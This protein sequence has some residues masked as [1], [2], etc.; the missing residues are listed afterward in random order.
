MSAWI[1]LGGNNFDPY[2][3]QAGTAAFQYW[4]PIHGYQPPVYRTFVENPGDS[5]DPR[6]HYFFNVSCNTHIYV[7]VD[8]PNCM[9]LLDIDT[10]VSTTNKCYGHDTSGLSG[11]ALVERSRNTADYPYFAR[12]NSVTFHGVAI[13]D[14][15]HYD[16][17]Y[18]VPHNQDQADLC[19]QY[20]QT[21]ERCTGF[22]TT[23]PYATT[24]AI[25]LDP[26]ENPND[27]YTVTWKY[28][29]PNRT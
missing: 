9:F 10:Q 26:N 16:A 13:T 1:G 12:F 21:G 22:D 19:T 5:N 4:D 24:G 14:N 15:G 23:K 20:D 11:E 3:I 27:M 25:E 2:L 8:S 28:Y 29:G 7:R 17:M 18:Q 6:A